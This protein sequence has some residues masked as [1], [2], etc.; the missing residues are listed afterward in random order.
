MDNENSTHK[1]RVELLSTIE[2]KIENIFSMHILIILS[3]IIISLFFRIYFTRFEFPLESPDALLYLLEAKQISSNNFDG[4]PIN[5]GWQA[6]LSFFNSFIPLEANSNGMDLIRMV[7][8]FISVGT[9]PVVYQLSK[10]IM[11]N[12]FSLVAAAFFAFDPNLI[13]NSTFGITEPIF[14]LCGLLSILFLLYRNTY[15]IIL[16]GIF[17]GF[18]LDIRLNG[19][20]LFVLIII[21]IL[22]QKNK[23]III[24]QL[25]IFL[26]VFVI[27]VIPFLLQSENHGI[28][29]Y[30]LPGEI[31][32]DASK[33]IA[34]SLESS[35]INLNFGEKLF[36]GISE[37]FK[38][39]FRI[40]IPYLALFVP[41]GLLMMLSNRDF[42]KN[43]IIFVIILSLIVA[44][45]QYLVSLEYRNLFFILPLFSII[46]AYGL[47]KI[48]DGKKYK[49]IFIILL[50]AGVI[51]LSYDMLRERHDIDYEL[52]VEKEMFG[53]YVANTFNGII[54][55]DLY[56]HIQ[57]NISDARYGYGVGGQIRNDNIGFVGFGPPTNSLKDITD[58][59]KNAKISHIVI[60]NNLD[61][62]SPEL[63]KI[64]S[65]EIKYPFLKEVFNSENEGYTKLRVKIFE[66]D[67]DKLE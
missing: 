54:M 67:H 8:I 46:A 10:K 58:Y 61:K 33:T 62:R 19:I 53:K 29:F 4:I 9:I 38:H 66:I 31:L 47:E 37:E 30:S 41:F 25:T 18:T 15:G 40:M 42:N 51:L 13:E 7:S 12:T 23:N 26:L 43:I 39:I 65:N 32:D 45:P 24:K 36:F 35:K 11:N 49:N 28:P 22:S 2:R 1:E 21:S 60:D 55:G 44:I 50:V 3:V 20:V 56:N 5:Y 17:A 64:Y 6:F 27:A 34:P 57:H 63:V 59:I 52:L 14:I 48:L 16:A